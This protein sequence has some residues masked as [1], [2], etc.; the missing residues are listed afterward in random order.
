[1]TLLTAVIILAVV[2]TA[3]A[4]AGGIVS[5]AQGGEYDRRHSGQFMFARVGLQ[6]LALVLL[7]I[8]LLVAGQR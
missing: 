3:G 1:M 8:A 5:M 6:G 2:A 4:L 7:L